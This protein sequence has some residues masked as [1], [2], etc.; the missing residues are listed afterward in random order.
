MEKQRC[1]MHWLCTVRRRWP[2]KGQTGAPM[3]APPGQHGSQGQGPAPPLFPHSGSLILTRHAGFFKTK[4]Q[5]TKLGSRTETIRQHPAL[6]ERM[7]G[8]QRPCFLRKV[9]K[10]KCPSRRHRWGFRIPLLDTHTLP[11]PQHLPAGTTADTLRPVRSADNGWM[12][13]VCRTRGPQG[14]LG[15]L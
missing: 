12:P 1:V 2:R 5:K 9:T 3:P 4:N 11:G 15:Y 8:P 6:F 13:T 7:L 14:A 10:F